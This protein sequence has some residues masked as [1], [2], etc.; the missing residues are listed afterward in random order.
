MHLDAVRIGSAFSGRISVENTIGLK[1][2]GE[3]ES[4]VAEVRKLP[5]NFNVGYSNIYTTKKEINVA[6]NEEFTEKRDK[7]RY[8]VND[9]KSFMKKES[10]RVKIN[11]K[12]YN[13][14]GRLGMY[15]CTVNIN[16]DNVNIGDKAIFDVNPLYVDNRIRREYK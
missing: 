13:I 11:E 5:K 9:I 15:H 8:L 12:S 3:L 16:Q 2:I 1:K 6:K 4:K 14:I 10:L 7:L